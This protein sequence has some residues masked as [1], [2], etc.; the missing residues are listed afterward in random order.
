MCKSESV[1][2]A[3]DDDERDW[4]KDYFK[5]EVHPY[6]LQFISLYLK[7]WMSSFSQLWAINVHVFS[8]DFWLLDKEFVYR[9]SLFI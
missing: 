2:A 8:S 9:F 5:H 4:M 7:M 6:E 3:E 1:S